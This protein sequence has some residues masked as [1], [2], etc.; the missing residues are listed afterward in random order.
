M[1]RVTVVVDNNPGPRGLIG[2]HGLSLW[3]EHDGRNLLYDTGA[4]R[5]L[6]PNLK[7]LGLDP[8]RLDAVVL[9]HGHYDHT[10]G[11]ADLLRARGRAG[12][13]TPV[14]CHPAVFAPHLKRGPDGP[15]DIGPPHAGQEAYDRMGAGFHFVIGRA[16]IQ[17]G[18]T[19]L[20]PIPRRTPFEKP[21]DDLATI[22]DGRLA[23][24]PFY[25]DL[26]LVVDAEAGPMVLT[27]C[28]HSG[29]IN[30][31]LAAEEAV[32]KR[33]LLLVGGTHLGPAP[34]EQRKRALAELAGRSELR[35]AAGH[36]TGPEMIKRLARALGQR[37]T[38]LEAGLVLEP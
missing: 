11:L 9:S 12:L 34:E 19:I 38:P 24:D 25:D 30:V 29:V 17:P 14:W 8:A 31:L 6:G 21:L 27:G 10:G 4:G 15:K 37:F 20:A 23:P 16:D 5:A 33:P 22:S 7:A 36:C 13:K 18:V 28:A 26:A 1:T 2:E 3:L 32:G 35:V